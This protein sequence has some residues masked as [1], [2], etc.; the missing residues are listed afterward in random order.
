[1]RIAWSTSLIMKRCI[2]VAAIAGVLAL[3][4]AA[5]A[6]PEDGPAC[7]PTTDRLELDLR[8]QTKGCVEVWRDGGA[9]VTSVTLE[10]SITAPALLAVMQRHPRAFGLSNPR[11]ELMVKKGFGP[12]DYELVQRVPGAPSIAVGSECEPLPGDESTVEHTPGMIK[13]RLVADVVAA[14]FRPRISEARARG[15]ALSTSRAL[16]DE[17]PKIVKRELVVRSRECD[18]DRR[19]LLVYRF[20][21][22]ETYGMRALDVDAT[23]GEVFDTLWDSVSRERFLGEE[24]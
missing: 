2:L 20:A 1:L 3:A 13:V 18:R 19:G 11:A 23:T 14:T 10:N 21:I 9:L 4:S 12:D 15:I 5:R 8:A 7:R 24:S 22:E 6:E 16:G 17:S